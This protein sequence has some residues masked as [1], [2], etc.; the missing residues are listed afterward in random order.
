MIKALFKFAELPSDAVIV[1]TTSNTHI[2]YSQL[3]PFVLQA[4]PAKNFENLWQFSKVYKEHLGVTGLPTPEW[5]KWREVGWNDP[6]AR[7][8]PMGKG[9]KP[10]YS[11]WK[12]KQ[13]GYIEARKRI[14]ALEYAKNV[15]KTKSFKILREQY[16]ECILYN[17]TMVLLD[18]DAYDHLELGMTLIDVI[19]NPKRKMGHAFVLIM[20]LMGKLEE[21]IQ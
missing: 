6:I 19:N 1:D 17:K 11:M 20:M 7:R 14:Y 2:L 3:S 15:I 9:R 5:Y 16:T 13:L 4:P 12:G 21:C 18:Y 10:E 8:Y